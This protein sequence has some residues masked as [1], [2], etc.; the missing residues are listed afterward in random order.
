MRPRIRGGREWP[1]SRRAVLADVDGEVGGALDLGDDPQGGDDLTE[2]GRDGRLE[3][4]E[5]VAALLD[6]DAG[7]V[8]IVVGDDHLLAPRRGPG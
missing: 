7:G 8:E 5:V 6:V 2:V 1:Y 4:Q 3:G